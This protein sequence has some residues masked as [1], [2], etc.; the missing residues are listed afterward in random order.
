MLCP[1]G[2]QP[3]GHP[4]GFTQVP[5]AVVAP[6]TRLPQC[7]RYATTLPGVLVYFQASLLTICVE[8]STYFGQ[9]E[10]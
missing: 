9:A 8:D 10:S 5:A 4:G 2:T 1:T 6:A 3:P 7:S